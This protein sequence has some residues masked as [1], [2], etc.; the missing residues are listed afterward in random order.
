M[1]MCPRGSGAC[2]F[3]ACKLGK[4]EHLWWFEWVPSDVYVQGNEEADSLAE[5]STSF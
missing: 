3:V 5:A 4:H 2:R 1:V